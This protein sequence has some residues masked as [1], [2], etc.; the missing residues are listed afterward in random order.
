MDAKRLE[1]KSRRELDKN[2]MSYNEQTL[3]VTSHKTAALRS[4][5][6]HL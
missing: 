4:P 5:T 6:S 3:E 2:A 1:K